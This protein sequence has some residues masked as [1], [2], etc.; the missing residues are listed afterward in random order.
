MA[1]ERGIRRLRRR[2]SIRPIATKWWY[3]WITS[4]GH[5]PT[6]AKMEELIHPGPKIG[7]ADT[8]YRINIWAKRRFGKHYPGHPAV[9]KT[10]QAVPGS[11][12]QIYHSLWLLFDADDPFAY[13]RGEAREHADTSTAQLMAVGTTSLQGI[14]KLRDSHHNCEGLDSFLI[15]AGAY[16][17]STH[18]GDEQLAI[19]CIDSTLAKLRQ[20]PQPCISADHVD[21][22]FTAFLQKIWTS[23]RAQ[24]YLAGFDLRVARRLE[25]LLA[26]RVR[27]K[28]AWYYASESPSLRTTE[29]GSHWIG[30]RR[31]VGAYSL[32]I[33]VTESSYRFHVSEGDVKDVARFALSETFVGEWLTPLQTKVRGSASALDDLRAVCLLTPLSVAQAWVNR[34]ARS[35][36]DKRRQ[37]QLRQVMDCFF[38]TSDRNAH[39]IL[40]DKYLSYEAIDTSLFQPP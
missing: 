28:S 24:C 14:R 34:E 38:A 12:G 13:W 27:S 2:S 26:A 25:S 9:R 29:P 11:L 1:A 33:E 7:K 19:H 6:E 20:L 16:L 8:P 23:V 37:A 15:L 3:W 31:P 4:K 35:G 22:L 40:G 30:F 10:E 36:V 18:V 39:N 17:E 32:G 21:D 5:Y